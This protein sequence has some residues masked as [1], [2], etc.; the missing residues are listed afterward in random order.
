LQQ[1]QEEIATI[2]EQIKK[3]E[4]DGTGGPTQQ[5][6]EPEVSVEQYPP[7]DNTADAGSSESQTPM[8][9]AE[10]EKYSSIL[11]RR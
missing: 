5:G 10:V 8:L 9:D 1:T 3:E 6:Q 2:D 7:E 4:A 11:N